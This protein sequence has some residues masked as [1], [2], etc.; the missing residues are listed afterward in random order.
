MFHRFV[1]WLWKPAFFRAVELGDGQKAAELLARFPGLVGARTAN[2]NTALHVAAAEGRTEI[3][4]M[5]IEKGADVHSTNKSGWTPL[6]GAAL[7][8]HTPAIRLLIESGAKVD[9]RDQGDNTPLLFA[10]T[11][12]KDAVQLLL[13]HGATVNAKNRPGNTP[14]SMVAGR[15]R[16]SGSSLSPADRAALSAVADVLFRHGATKD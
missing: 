11:K 3:A 2:D 1:L 4:K 8:G 13:E 10:S 16:D 15:L 6:H 9:A 7:F 5:L 12:H 14:L